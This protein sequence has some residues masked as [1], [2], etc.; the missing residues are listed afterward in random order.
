MKT[1]KKIMSLMLFAIVTVMLTLTVNAAGNGT[2]TVN[3]T[4]EGKTYEIYKIFDLTLSGSGASAKVAYTIDTDWTAFFATGGLGESYI[5]DTNSGNLSSIIVNGSV[6]YIN[7][8]ETNV[9][10]FA[11]AALE[12]ASRNNIA[13][14]DSKEGTR[15]GRLVFDGLDL[16]YYLVYPKGATE[17]LDGNASICSLTSTVPTAEVNVKAGYPTID[18][19]ADKTNVDV[20]EIVTFT[21]TGTVPNTKGYIKYRYVLKDTMSAGLL[22]NENLANLKVVIDGNEID[23]SRYSLA[24]ANNGFVLEFDMTKFQAYVGKDVIVTYQAKVTEEA[25]K[26]TTTKNRLTLEY[27]NN[28]KN[29]EEMVPTPPIEVPVYSSK[30]TVKKID[31]NNNETLL[32]G[33]KFVLTKNEGNKTLYYRA[34]NKDGNF[35]TSTDTTLVSV[36]SNVEVVEWVEDIANATVLVTDA[37]GN[38]VFNGMK[39]GT[40]YLVETEAP[41]GYNKLTEPVEIKV[42]YNENNQ[43]VETGVDHNV[44][45]ENNSGTQLPTTGGMGTTLFVVLGSLLVMGT[46]IVLVTNKRMASEEI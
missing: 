6:K 29:A 22:F 37:N 43:L 1:L 25:I 16:G 14:D 8:T 28:P 35:I 7:V 30:V 38:A 20:G 41:E 24:I 39:N 44:S 2:I 5:T 46:A 15:D 34:I 12:Y 33:A 13:A 36:A 32:S 21:V 10:E 19:V 27:S 18:K 40:Y 17:I 4:T 11:Q 23:P 26:S 9:A 45:V 3:G 42:G 31:A